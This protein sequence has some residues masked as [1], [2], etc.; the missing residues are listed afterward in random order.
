MNISF[1]TIPCGRYSQ[2]KLTSGICCGTGRGLYFC[3]A[4]GPSGRSI[5]SDRSDRRK[6]R[7]PCRFCFLMTSRAAVRRYPYFI[8]NSGL[9][10]MNLYS[11][12]RK[13]QLARIISVCPRGVAC[14]RC[15][16]LS[17][18][19]ASSRLPDARAARARRRKAHASTMGFITAVRSTPHREHTACPRNRAPQTGHLLCRSVIINVL[20]HKKAV[21][22]ILPWRWPGT[23]RHYLRWRHSVVRKDQWPLPCRRRACFRAIHWRDR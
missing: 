22:S 9:I 5:R 19:R 12:G 7:A 18:A 23:L 1:V 15:A 2:P 6:K 20:R 14:L 17:S 16:R 10:A 8:L 13:V 4:G 3:Q 11:P 21:P